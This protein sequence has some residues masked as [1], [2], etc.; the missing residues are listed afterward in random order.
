MLEVPGLGNASPRSALFDQSFGPMDLDFRGAWARDASI[1]IQGRI[2]GGTVWL[3]DNVTIEGIDRG[4][5]PAPWSQPEIP[6]P[7]LRLDVSAH[8]PAQLLFIE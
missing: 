5:A 2:S 1:R 3:P 7:T 4:R 6:F 8:H